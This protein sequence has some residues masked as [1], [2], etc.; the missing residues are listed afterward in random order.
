MPHEALVEVGA[1]QVVVN[2][3]SP[4]LVGDGREVIQ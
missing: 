1:A 3:R 2:P 4:F